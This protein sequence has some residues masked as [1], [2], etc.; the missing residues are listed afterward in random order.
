MKSVG[1][2]EFLAYRR[3]ETDLPTAIARAQQATRHYA[4]RQATWFRHQIMADLRLNEQCYYQN[5]E[6]IFRF[7]RGLG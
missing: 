4:K 3:G 2:P 6:E 5:R 7:I 1:V